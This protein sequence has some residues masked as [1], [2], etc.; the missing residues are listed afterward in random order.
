MSDQRDLSTAYQ[1]WEQRWGDARQRAD[2]LVPEQPLVSAVPFLQRSGV[3]DVIDIGCGVGRHALYLA[4]QGFSVAGVD[5]SPIGLDVARDTAEEGNLSIEL[6]TGNFTELPFPAERFD[7]ALAWNVIYHGDGEVVSRALDEIRRVLRPGGLL[8]GT[9]ISKRHYRYGDG[10]QIR[11]N[12]YIVDDDEE[13]AH[14]HFYCNERELL[15]LLDGFHLYWLQDR[16]QREPGTW[17]WE[18]LAERSPAT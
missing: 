7:L 18:F 16:E 4:E 17:H 3:R 13:K 15:E 5:L 9:M 14:A 8:L 10:Q 6:E 2:W 11:P 12:T 1:A